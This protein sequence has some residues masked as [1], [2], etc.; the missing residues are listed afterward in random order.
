MKGLITTISFLVLGAFAAIYIGFGFERSEDD[1]AIDEELDGI[2]EKI[3]LI[4]SHVVAENTP[5]GLAAS[6]FANLVR[7]KTD[8]WVEVQ[9]FPN[10]LLYEAQEEFDALKENEVHLI[11]PALSEVTVHDPN[12]MIMD[13]PYL[14]KDE[15]M[16]RAAFDGE[17]GE[18]LFESLSNQGFHGLTFWDNGFKQFTN[19]VRPIRKP[20]DVE[21]LSMRVMPSEALIDTYQYL[22]ASAHVYS[23]N[24]VYEIL[25]GGTVDG[26]ENTLSNIF[27]KGFY[28]QQE[29]MTVSNHSYL[30]YAVL[31]NESFWDTIPAE[32]QQSIE[33]AMKETT[34]WLRNHSTQL[35]KE[36]LKK[37]EDSEKIVIHELTEEE[38][39]AWQEH[40]APLYEKYEEQIGNE[41]FEK[42][43]QLEK[44]S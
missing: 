26:T 14:F 10:G 22:G 20:E 38:R 16:V 44:A 4:F 43:R 21:N 8:G 40:F 39:R 32:H 13:M 33:E 42:V 25:S 9:V 31:M 15:A 27:S 1:Y 23:F 30:G 28:R 5:K 12:W 24:E 35:N 18:I 2:N 7:E 29:Y 19:N 37:L 34:E 36:M 17:V 6:R 3:V 11:A 41:L